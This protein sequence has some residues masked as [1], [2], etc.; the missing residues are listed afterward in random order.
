MDEFPL[1][2]L[3]PDDCFQWERASYPDEGWID[4][5]QG[6]HKHAEILARLDWHGVRLELVVSRLYAYTGNFKTPVES[7]LLRLRKM[8]R[9]AK[10]ARTDL[11]RLAGE[12]EN[13][14]TG[15]G[16][17]SALK[18][19]GW[20]KFSILPAMMREYGLLMQSA[21]RAWR[22]RSSFK[23]MNKTWLLIYVLSYIELRAPESAIS[24]LAHLLEASYSAHGIEKDITPDAVRQIRNRYRRQ[25][26]ASYRRLR[27]LAAQ[28]PPR[29]QT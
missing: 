27:D 10:K 19:A 20:A 15:P 8:A 22:K 26:P 14:N 29:T 28:V 5:F 12:L 4:R 11:D 6:E 3:T 18:E 21:G 17:A 1:F 9:S 2:R 16:I 24:D 25:H 23:R 7:A 13:L